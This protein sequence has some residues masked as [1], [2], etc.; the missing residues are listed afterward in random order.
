MVPETVR[1]ARARAPVAGQAC[2]RS[3]RILTDLISIARHELTPDQMRRL[4][5]IAS[6]AKKGSLVDAAVYEQLVVDASAGLKA[7]PARATKRAA[8]GRKKATRRTAK[9]KRG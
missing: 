8:P 4:R 9:K 1:P 2:V 6:E 7:A 3:V 5:Q